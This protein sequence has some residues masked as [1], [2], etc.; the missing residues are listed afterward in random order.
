MLRAELAS[1]LR[2]TGH[3][4]LRASETG[5][6]RADDAQILERAVQEERTLVTLD[7]HFGD[8]VVLP[9][10]KHFGVIRV[11]AHPASTENVSMLLLPL[12]AKHLQTDFRNKL[13]ILSASRVRWIQ[14]AEE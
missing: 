3:D 2:E 8:W 13:V 12:L 1:A 4:V 10:S 9:L 11:R 7:G 14:T 6:A 5:Q